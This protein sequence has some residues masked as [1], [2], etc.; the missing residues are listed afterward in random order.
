MESHHDFNHSSVV[1]NNSSPIELTYIC[2]LDLVRHV[3]PDNRG[4]YCVNQFL[5]RLTLNVLDCTPSLSVVVSGVTRTSL[6]K[7]VGRL[8]P[9][10]ELCLWWLLHVLSPCCF[11]VM[12]SYVCGYPVHC[13]FDAPRRALQVVRSESVKRFGMSNDRWTNDKRLGGR[14]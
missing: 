3:P 1:R 4:V 5:T 10:I 6:T 8:H 2:G 14:L 12:L 9:R 7:A 11:L 13:E